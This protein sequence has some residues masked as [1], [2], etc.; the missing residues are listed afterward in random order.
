[1]NGLLAKLQTIFKRMNE[2]R[3]REGG[4]DGGEEEKKMLLFVL[5]IFIY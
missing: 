5:V 1:M 3:E 4:G 2:S